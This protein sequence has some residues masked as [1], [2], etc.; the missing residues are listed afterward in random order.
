M[1]SWWTDRG[2]AWWVKLDRA[3]EHAAA[4]VTETKAYFQGG[5]FRVE[6][7]PGERAHETVYGIR[8]SQ[9]IPLRASAIIGDALH[10][11]RSALDSVAFE[12]AR[13]HIGRDLTEDEEKATGFPI[14]GAPARFAEFFK[15]PPE[16]A[17]LYGPR[18][19]DAMRVV[20]PGAN[21]DQAAQY[22]VQLFET[23]Q[24]AVERDNLWLLNRLSIIDRHRRLHLTVAFPELV[25]WG[26]DEPSHYQWRWGTQ[27]FD[28]GAVLGYLIGDPDHPEPPAELEH[29]MDLRIPDRI[30][31]TADVTSL[32]R[33]LHQEVQFCVARVWTQWEALGPGV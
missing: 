29:V 16:R 23:R 22:G 24:E 15:R 20:Q 31:G 28:D 27:P 12:L 21:Y 8:L 1:S 10:N 11:L 2:L 5:S 17:T 13:Q 14:L 6:Q 26:S 25:H 32:L 18:E 9:P 33:T 3:G 19:Q 30:A 7:E 4:L